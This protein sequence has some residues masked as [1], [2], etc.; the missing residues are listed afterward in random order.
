MTAH[1]SQEDLRQMA[2]RW[3]PPSHDAHRFQIHTDTTD[4]FRV[5]YGNVV[6]LNGSPYLIRHNAKEGRFGIDD[7]VKFWVKRAIDLKNGNLKILKLVFYEK[8]TSHIGSI[9]FE[10][11]RSPS[12]EA[13]ILDLVAGHKNFMHGYAVK[14]QAENLIRVLDFIEGKPLYD[15]VQGIGLD[16]QTYFYDR[17]PVILNNFTECIEA[18]HFLHQH[19]EKHGD[20]RRDH[21]L[22]DRHSGRYRWIDFDFNYRH[23]ENVYGYD[24]FGL[25]NVL[26][27]LVGMGDVLLP[28]LKKQ[29]HPA[30]DTLVEEDLNIVFNNRVANLKKI[31]PYIPDPLNRILMHFSKGANWFYENTVQL[32]DDLKAYQTSIPT[33]Q[34]TGGVKK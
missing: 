15:Y 24:L 3:L 30:L 8:F 9:A 28:E 13:R 11:F 14:D 6:V 19:G 5:E 18:V 26:I 7:D 34:K 27:F 31:Y 29:G 20:I 21:I 17:L 16:H 25:G 4:F 22:I 2:S 33:L 1:P 12:K 32:L 10:C 23:R